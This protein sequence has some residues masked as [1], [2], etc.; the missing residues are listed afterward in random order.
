[1]VFLQNLWHLHRLYSTET[2]SLTRLSLLLF[3]FHFPLVWCVVAHPFGL[4]EL[5][6]TPAHPDQA[7]GS[8]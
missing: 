6:V 8:L 1:M 2:T 3:F 5:L 7:S 4:H